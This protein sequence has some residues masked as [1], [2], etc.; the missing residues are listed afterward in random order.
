MFAHEPCNLAAY[1]IEGRN[2]VLRCR[3]KR[4]VTAVCD[5]VNCAQGATVG[6]DAKNIADRHVGIIDRVPTVHAKCV[7]SNGDLGLAR[8]THRNRGLFVR[9]CFFSMRSNSATVRLPYAISCS[10]YMRTEPG[11]LH[12]IIFSVSSF[13]I[14]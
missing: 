13:K 1:C 9:Y 11:Q 14:M 12:S 10:R 5:L 4:D 6:Q 7:S 2:C 3:D 8:V